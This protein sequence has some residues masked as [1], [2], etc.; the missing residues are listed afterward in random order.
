MLHEIHTETTPPSLQRKQWLRLVH[1]HYHSYLFF[2][3]SETARPVGPII[4]LSSAFHSASLGQRSSSWENKEVNLRQRWHHSNHI[5]MYYTAASE[6][7][8]HSQNSTG[9]YSLGG[10][11]TEHLN[12]YS[13][14]SCNRSAS[15]WEV[16]R[17]QEWWQLI[18]RATGSDSSLRPQHT[19]PLNNNTLT[20]NTAKHTG[21]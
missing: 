18:E 13:I 16:Q 1:R 19:A 21:R 6:V 14:S 9:T 2:L 5:I 17:F 7:M 15:Q 4:L 8:S 3:P 12:R 10:N 11:G 20:D